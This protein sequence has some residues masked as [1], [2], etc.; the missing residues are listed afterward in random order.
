M[1]ATTITNGFLMTPR[2]HRGMNEAGLQEM[3]ISIDG[4]KPDDVSKKTLKSLLGS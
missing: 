3:Q 4:V 1:I 2:P